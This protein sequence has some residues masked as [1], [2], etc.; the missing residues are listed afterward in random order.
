MGSAPRAPA[1]AGQFYPGG[2]AELARA[3]EGCF[4]DGRGP[5]AVPTPSAAAGRRTVR[6]AVVP[7]AGYPFSGPIAAHV[8]AALGREAPPEAVVILGVDHH[9][10]GGLAALSRRPWLTPL[11]TVPPARAIASAVEIP[12]IAV[13]ESAHTLEHSIEVELPFLQ[14]V[15]PAVPIVPI[16]IHFASL[17][18][19][20]SVAEALRPG[21]AGR[22]VVVLASSDF[23]HYEPA[24]IA[25]AH[26]GEMLAPLVAGDAA[27]LYELVR[28]RRYSMCGIAPVTV[29]LRYLAGEGVRGR[30]LAAG[31]SGE[32]AP[33]ATVV[34]YAAVVFETPGGARPPV[35]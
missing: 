16:Q 15:W 25:R 19:L 28:R 27:G 30:L 5:G 4:T 8:F 26:D 10:V 20:N 34:G 11:G 12:P 3:V 1:V 6:A 21:L 22:D 31:H 17:A 23:S 24:E 18:A 29:L 2:K 7:H 35:K 14:R 13:D 32:A 9:G 33:M